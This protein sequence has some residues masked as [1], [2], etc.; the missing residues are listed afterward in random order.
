[1]NRRY[2]TNG[3]NTHEQYNVASYNSQMQTG[4][5]RIPFTSEEFKSTRRILS[6]QLGPEYVST[7]AAFGGSKFAKTILPP[8]ELV[9][10]ILEVFSQP[11]ELNAFIQ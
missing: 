9:L 6:M 10:L 2:T 1:M 3:G 4:F 5:G 7:R 8:W 11:P